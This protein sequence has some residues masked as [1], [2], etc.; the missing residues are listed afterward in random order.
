MTLAFLPQVV[1][2]NQ[3]AGEFVIT[4]PRAYHS[5]FNQGYNFAE[6]VNFCT[7]DWVSLECSGLEGR[8]RSVLGKLRHRG[9]QTGPLNLEPAHSCLLG[10]SALS[11]TA[12]SVDTAS[13]PMRNSYARWLLAQ[14]SWTWTWQQLYIRRCSSWYRRSGVY[15]RP[16]WRRWVVGRMPYIGHPNMAERGGRGGPRK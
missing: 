16:C 5:G 14:R 8:S 9:L 11:T 7:A 15:E 3:C 1:R 4:F 12:G 10:A 2:T 13:S 6:A